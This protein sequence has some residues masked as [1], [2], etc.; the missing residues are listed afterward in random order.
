[1][2]RKRLAEN[3]ELVWWVNRLYYSTKLSI[4]KI[5][6]QVRHSESSVSKLVLSKSEYELLDAVLEDKLNE[7]QK[8]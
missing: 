4:A 5:A 7:L 2:G 6:K 1:M 3:Q 8:H